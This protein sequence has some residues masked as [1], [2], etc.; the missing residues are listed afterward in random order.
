[1]KQE[2]I[3]ALE[4]FTNT[5]SEH[6]NKHT[7]G[8]LQETIKQGLFES[9]ETALKLFTNSIELF[10]EHHLH[11]IKAVQLFNDELDKQSLTQNQKLFLYERLCKY[12]N[13]TDFEEIDLFP[14]QKLLESHKERLKV[15]SQ[16]QTAIT[17]NI[18]EIL[19]ELIQKELEQLPETLKGLEP[20]Q[21]LNVLCK[22]VPFVL[23]KVDS[24][25]YEKDEP[26]K[27]SPNPFGW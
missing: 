17:R 21:R 7:F 13:D 5:E 12:L 2:E 10:Q 19:K 18:R 8:M 25:H 1:M 9:P 3:K 6:W 16:P 23:P 4:S 11:P 27:N 20:A 14:V 26:G 22:L 24:V 15:E